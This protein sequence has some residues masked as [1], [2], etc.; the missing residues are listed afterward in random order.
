MDRFAAD[1]IKR[2]V[3]LGDL[4]KSLLICILAGWS[5]FVA[6]SGWA[7]DGVA[8]LP[9]RGL[10]PMVTALVLICL[11]LLLLLVI[12]IIFA[13]VGRQ[14]SR[15]ALLSSEARL[16]T[17]LGYAPVIIWAIDRHGI[18]TFSEGR[19]LKELGLKPGEAVGMSLFEKYGDNPEVVDSVRRALNG[20]TVSSVTQS[21]GLSFESK[22]T[23]IFD[24][25]GRVTGAIG[26]A[27]DKTAQHVAEE[28]LGK[29]EQQFRS[30]VQA[31]PLGIHI[32]ELDTEGRL[33]FRAANPAADDI[34]GVDNSRFVD[35]PLEEAF[36]PL[37]DTEVS[38]RYRM[39]AADGKPWNTEQLLYQDGRITG[40]FE[41]RAFQTA[42]G[43]MAAMFQDITKRKQAEEALKES[44]NRYRDLIDSVTD[45]LYTQD[46]E[47]HF[48][49]VNK[50]AARTLGYE[51]QEIVGR[52]VTEFMREK[53]RHLFYDV[54]LPEIKAMGY[55]EGL[56]VYVNRDGAKR[57]VEYRSVF[58]TGAEGRQTVTGSGRDI[59]EKILADRE[60]RRLQEQLIQS[61]KME[62]IGALATGVAHDFNNILQI[63]SGYLQLLRAQPGLM[64]Q[65]TKYF[66]EIEQANQRAVELVKQLLT[67]SRKK[68][69]QLQPTDVNEELT[70]TVRM[71]KRT[72]PKTIE[73]EVSLA[74]GLW[75]INGDPG[76][77]N[78]VLIN[79]VNNAVDAMGESGRIFIETENAI[80][81]DEFVAVHMKARPGNYVL[82]RVGDNGPGIEKEVL[83]HIY[84]PFYTT[85]EPGKGTGL[86]LASVYGIVHGHS[87]FLSCYSH[88]GQGTVFH[89]YL[90]ALPVDQVGLTEGGEFPHPI[91]EGHETILLVDDEQAI[92]DIGRDMLQR[93]GYKV[94]SAVSGEHAVAIFEKRMAELDLVILDLGMPGMGG[95]KC[96]QRLKA[97][98]SGIKIIIAS[99][100]DL[101]G[102]AENMV[103][104]GASGFIAKPYRLRDMMNNIRQVLD[105]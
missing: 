34:L 91:P 68:G 99:G 104:A 43:K 70:Q 105:A 96:L 16:Q 62:A 66:E 46:L 44:E 64:P 13:L 78:Q 76:Q 2:N 53:E 18:F 74:E 19:G 90:P 7:L 33:I 84:E 32:Y 71:L 8:E 38:A 28:M 14:K 57:Y 67:F 21:D 31:S 11:L 45:L 95:F 52:H 87:G 25:N 65:G 101:N 23:P 12:V 47:G 55:Q 98:N 29:S 10:S 73:L 56:I 83:A 82:I 100:Y 3:V 1:G 97:I 40:A 58:Q 54:F 89:I 75:K 36:P 22:C 35:L 4:T 80:L 15:Q 63:I 9:V 41:V 24:V 20:E 39:A 48:I 102:Q 103:E 60:V 94:L 6:G 30:I 49:T 85:K 69:S 59:T 17:L 50:A 61:Q 37:K 26:V 27:I 79:L 86:G 51:P 77:I 42:P 81:D 88:V 72:I 92:L 93:Y 5:V